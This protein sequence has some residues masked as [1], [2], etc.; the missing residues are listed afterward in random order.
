MPAREQARTSYSQK[1]RYSMLIGALMEANKQSICLI[2]SQFY[3]FH[4]SSIIEGVQL[5]LL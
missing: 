5:I 2:Y 1:G 4:M 3:R